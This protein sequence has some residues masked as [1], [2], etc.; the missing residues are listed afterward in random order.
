ML[1]GSVCPQIP[2]PLQPLFPEHKNDNCNIW[3]SIADD[4]ITR[5]A[6]N[7]KVA[8]ETC[9]VEGILNSKRSGGTSM[10]LYNFNRSCA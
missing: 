7:F 3:Y 10:S 4:N 8:P 1:S 5:R 9:H 6:I 2:A